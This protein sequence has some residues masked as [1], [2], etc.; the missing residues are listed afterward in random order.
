MNLSSHRDELITE[1]DERD[2]ARRE[3]NGCDGIH[4]ML[5]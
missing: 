1:I 5:W 3:T 2:D 4:D